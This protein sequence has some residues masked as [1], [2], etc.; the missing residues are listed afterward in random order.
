VP[1]SQTD[2]IF[3]VV[4]ACAG[5]AKKRDVPISEVATARD[6][7]NP[8]RERAGLILCSVKWVF[9]DKSPVSFLLFA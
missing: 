1:A 6:L 7:R 2:W 4:A 8:R 3:Q 5:A 9:I